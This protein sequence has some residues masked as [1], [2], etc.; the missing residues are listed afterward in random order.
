MW[1]FLKNY[2]EGS[3]SLK[4]AD[5]KYTVYLIVLEHGNEIFSGIELVCWSYKWQ[6][7]HSCILIFHGRRV[8]EERATRTRSHL[9]KP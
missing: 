9:I 6:T 2:C 5:P 1:F 7:L 8:I 3:I 4:G